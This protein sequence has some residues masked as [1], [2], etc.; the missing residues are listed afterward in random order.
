M[1][2]VNPHLI[3][4]AKQRIKRSFVPQGDPAMMGGGGDP[5]AAAAPPDAGGG[6]MPPGGGGGGDPLAS[7]MPMIQ[8]AVQQAITAQGGAG[9]AAGGGMGG[10]GPL[11]PKIDVNVALMQLSKMVARIAEA[12]GV[13]IPA[14]EM[15]ATPQDLGAMAQQQQTGAPGGAPGGAEGAAGGMPPAAGMPDMSAGPGQLPKMGFDRLSGGVA[16]TPPDDVRQNNE[17]L[18]DMGERASAVLSFMDHRRRLAS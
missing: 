9:G 14:H 8:Q 3:Q 16:Y 13:H 4:M 11:K 15:I 2:I 7:L 1:S 10:A 18:R 17:A 12:L 5:A 6:M